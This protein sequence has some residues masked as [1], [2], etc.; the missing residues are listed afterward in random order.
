[1]DWSQFESPILAIK[2]AVHQA[3]EETWG[4]QNEFAPQYLHSELYSDKNESWLVK[5]QFVCDA[6]D[7]KY[8]KQEE[9]CGKKTMLRTLFIRTK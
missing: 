2:S 8:D 1:M 7:A 4:E 3:R 6:C 9:C 5:E